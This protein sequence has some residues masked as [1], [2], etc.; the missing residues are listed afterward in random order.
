M[1]IPM[2]LV[3]GLRPKNPR[4]PTKQTFFWLLQVE[5]SQAQPIQTARRRVPHSVVK[6]QPSSRCLNRWRR[7]PYL[8]RVPPCPTAS[9]Q[10]ELVIAPVTQI[11]GVRDPHVSP[12]GRHGPMNKRP[13]SINSARQESGVFV[14]RRH[15][16]AISLERS[17][18]RKS[19][20]LNSSHANISYA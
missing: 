12:E 2:P 4:V 14:F 16:D 1:D 13:E 17:E 7:Q 3:L 10:H 19:T 6:H 5:K 9:L 18:D 11:G 20:R 15:D 8:V